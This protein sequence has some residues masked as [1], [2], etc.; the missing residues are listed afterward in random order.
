MAEN[1]PAPDSKVC[2]IFV[3]HG[4]LD[5]P[6]V[7]PPYIEAELSPDQLPNGFQYYAAG[8]V[9]ERYLGKFKMAPW[10]TAAALKQRITVKQNTKKASFTSG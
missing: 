10:H 5:L 4:A 9:H 6:N 7:N 1:T 8:H 2:N 3:F